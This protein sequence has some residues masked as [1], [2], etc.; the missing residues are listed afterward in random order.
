MNRE[1]RVGMIVKLNAMIRE[2]TTKY[3]PKSIDCEIRLHA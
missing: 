1:E 3:W 2:L